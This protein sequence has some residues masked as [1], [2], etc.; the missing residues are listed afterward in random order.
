MIVVR[1]FFVKF[2]VCV[3]VVSLVVK[4]MRLGFVFL[5]LIFFFIYIL[6]FFFWVFESIGVKG[7][8]GLWLLL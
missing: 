5:I 2:S 7:M 1:F 3:R 8:F 4:F 6:I